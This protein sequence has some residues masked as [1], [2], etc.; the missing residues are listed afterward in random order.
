MTSCAELPIA[1]GF[2][3]SALLGVAS[4]M[5]STTGLAAVIAQSDAEEL[6][7]VLRHPAATP[8]AGLAVAVELVLAKMPFTGSRLEPAGLAG[9]L[10]FAGAAGALAAR[11]KA[12]AVVPAALVAIAAAALS[13]KVAHDLR[14]RLAEH[15]PDRAVALVEDL[16]AIGIAT[17]GCRL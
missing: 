3:S 15:F 1:R 9:R 12:R 13:A 4:G 14:A 10:V 16:A 8:A 11:G 17:A 5:R 2:L 7:A 6:P